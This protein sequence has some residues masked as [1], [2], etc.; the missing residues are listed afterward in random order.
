MEKTSVRDL[1][2][3]PKNLQLYF[4]GSNSLRITPHF[5]G[6]PQPAGSKLDEHHPREVIKGF[7]L[8]Y[9]KYVHEPRKKTRPYFALN[10]GS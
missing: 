9:E 1:L 6:F 2:K 10:P 4:K 8:S 7:L 5:G 3:K